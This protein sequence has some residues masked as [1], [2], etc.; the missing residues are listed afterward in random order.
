MTQSILIY[1]KRLLCSAH[2]NCNNTDTFLK[3]NYCDMKSRLLYV[4]SRSAMNTS[5]FLFFFSKQS[6]KHF[7]INNS[8]ILPRSVN[9]ATHLFPRMY[10]CYFSVCQIT[11]EFS[12]TDFA[13][14]PYCMLL[15]D[16]YCYTIYR[17]KVCATSHDQTVFSSV[18][19]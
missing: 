16:V 18:L 12:Y 6:C 13:A 9:S 8:N 17:D 1:M 3:L 15:W 2:F 19:W 4:G 10:V 7:R 11:S 5:S 14:W